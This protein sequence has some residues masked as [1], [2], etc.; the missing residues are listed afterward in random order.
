MLR[1]DYLGYRVTCTTC[2]RTKQPVGRSVPLGFGGCGPECPG[3]YLEPLPSHLW[4][5]ESE[6][7]FG[8]EVPR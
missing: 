4:P 5:R 6:A 3:F 8:Y 7:D 2:G 1:T